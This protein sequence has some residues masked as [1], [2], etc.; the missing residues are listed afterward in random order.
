MISNPVQI[1]DFGSPFRHSNRF[2]WQT[3]PII[4]RFKNC[5]NHKGFIIVLA[6]LRKFFIF[7]THGKLE[8]IQWR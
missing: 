5:A 7:T 6:S 2:F 4:F 1:S 3:A 8:E